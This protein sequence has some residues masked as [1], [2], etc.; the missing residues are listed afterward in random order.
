MKVLGKLYVLL[1]FVSIDVSVFAQDSNYH[2]YLSF[3]QTI[4]AGAGTIEVQDFIVENR[5][6]FMKPQDCVVQNQYAGNFYPSV[7][8]LWECAERLGPSD[9]FGRT[10][11]ENLP[12][13]IKVGV[14][15][16]AII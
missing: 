1:L 5:F 4:M 8:P 12:E 2:I 10:M 11:V 6:Q 3:G 16:V 7:S 14:S 9:Y 13:N 15:V